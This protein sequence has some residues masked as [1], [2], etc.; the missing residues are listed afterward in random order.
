MKKILFAFLVTFLMLNL[1]CNRDDEVTPPDSMVGTWYASKATIKGKVTVSGISQ[2]IN[3]TQNTDVCT[4]KTTF[5]FN[6]D[7]TGSAVVSAT[8]NGECITNDPQAYTYTYDKANRVVKI[9]QGGVTQVMNLTFQSTTEFSYS[10]N[11]NNVNFGDYYPQYE[12]YYF[13]G[14]AI[15]YFKKK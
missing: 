14:T 8:V 6:A 9:T 3:S 2:D 4:Q 15:S 7:G 1:S 5:T 13:T 11:L 10:E 12:G